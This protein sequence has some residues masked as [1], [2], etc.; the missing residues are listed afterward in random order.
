MTN[1]YKL[2]TS[3]TEY[4]QACDAVLRRAER[5]I[6]IFDR[7]LAALRL[8]DAQRL[9]I[10]ANFVQA[11]VLR[12][13]RMVVHDP[14]LLERNAPKLLRLLVRLSHLIEVRQT[15]DNLRH[16]ADTHVLADAGHGV[17][18]FH[19]DQPRSALVFDD[20]AY[21]TPWRQRFEELWDLSHPCVRITTTGL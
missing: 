20:P 13:V 8:E 2:L 21:I 19:V 17:R 16:L 10:L 9:A 7:D 14:E 18:R 11:D 12:K 5:E 15:P 3:E 1:G 6:L 4:R